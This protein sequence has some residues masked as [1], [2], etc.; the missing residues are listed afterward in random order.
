MHGGGSGNG[1]IVGVLTGTA[2]GAVEDACNSLLV[3]DATY[4]RQVMDTPKA[5]SASSPLLIREQA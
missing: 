1:A 3:L 4:I 2:S 5:V